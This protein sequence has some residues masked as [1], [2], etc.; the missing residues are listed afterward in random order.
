M[1]PKPKPLSD[2]FDLKK[3]LELKKR[4]RDQKL[5]YNTPGN[6]PPTSTTPTVVLMVP[7]PID[8]GED[9]T[10]RQN[11]KAMRYTAAKNSTEQRE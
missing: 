7:S 6:P 8:S 3:F 5:G 10:E 1:K 2:N 4:E 11:C 9:D